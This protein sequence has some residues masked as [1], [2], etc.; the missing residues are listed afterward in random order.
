VTN[1]STPP[2]P[3]PVAPVALV[4]VPLAPLLVSTAG[5][6]DGQIDDL[7]LRLYTDHCVTP[8]KR[9]LVTTHDGQG[10]ECFDNDYGHGFWTAAEKHRRG[11]AKDFVDH[12]RVQ[13]AK[14]IVPVISG[15]VPGTECWLITE[16]WSHK[17]PRPVQRLYIVR[18]EPYLVYLR[19]RPNG[20]A[21]KTAY[22]P[23]WADIKRYTERQRRIWQRT[24]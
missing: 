21:F 4:T 18:N 15:H 7:G 9:G 19:T 17:H 2:G 12:K 6:N 5:M 22:C 8:A 11:W 23:S 20:W 13:R 24:A 16:Y 14:W 1:P 3:Q 10:V